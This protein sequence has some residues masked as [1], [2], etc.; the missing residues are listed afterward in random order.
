MPDIIRCAE[1]GATLQASDR[2]CPQCGTSAP[3]EGV[4]VAV[5]GDGAVAGVAGD[6]RP[7]AAFAAPSSPWPEQVRSGASGIVNQAQSAPNAPIAPA[8]EPGAGA[9]T[10][11]ND[12][13]WF[14]STRASSMLG[15]A[16]MLL[17]GGLLLMGIG[18]IDSTGTIVII[19]LLVLEGAAA[20]LLLGLARG[21][22]GAFVK[23]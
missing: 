10:R 16:L 22:A 19:S 4:A 9:T 5:A 14:L 23:G 3:S 18:Q 11:E 1:C 20:M 21:V 15:T 17:I 7:D 6:L 13:G 8:T 12:K 2:F